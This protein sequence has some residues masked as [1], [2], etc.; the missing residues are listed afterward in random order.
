MKEF[1][2]FHSMFILPLWIPVN[3][4]IIIIIES[5]DSMIK[6][7]S[8]TNL[9]IIYKYIIFCLSGYS[10]IFFLVH[11]NNNNNTP[12][13]RKWKKTERKLKNKLT[14]ATNNKRFFPYWNNDCVWNNEKDINDYIKRNTPP[15]HNYSRNDVC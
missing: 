15:H 5:I 3:I 10:G 4:I 11:S 1:R 7:G 6:I 14:R 9:H 8:Q 13:E 2:I 12:D